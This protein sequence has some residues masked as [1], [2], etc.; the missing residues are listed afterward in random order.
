MLTLGGDRVN[1]EVLA[2]ASWVP[3]STVLEFVEAAG[4][5]N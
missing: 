1:Y 5:S 3:S 4:I 2:F